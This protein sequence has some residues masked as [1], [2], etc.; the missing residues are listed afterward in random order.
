[1]FDNLG[2]SLSRRYPL[3]FQGGGSDPGS[4]EKEE[5]IETEEDDED[6]G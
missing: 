4:G 6:D 3:S 2:Q 1:M 5:E